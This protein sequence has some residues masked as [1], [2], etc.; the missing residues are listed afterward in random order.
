M[1]MNNEMIATEFCISWGSTGL[2]MTTFLY[3]LTLRN[4]Q[5]P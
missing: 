3:L 4:A 5:D 2:F 1:F